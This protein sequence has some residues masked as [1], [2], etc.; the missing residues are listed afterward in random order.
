MTIFLKQPAKVVL[1]RSVIVDIAPPVEFVGWKLA[2]G[3]RSLWSDGGSNALETAFVNCDIKLVEHIASRE[4]IP[5]QFRQASV[6]IEVA[7]LRWRHFIVYWPATVAS[8]IP[9]GNARNFVEM[10]I[11]D[12]LTAWYASRARQNFEC[13]RKFFLYDAREGMRNDLLTESEGES[14]SS[15]SYLDNENTRKNLNLC[16]SEQFVFVK[17]YIQ[18]SFVQSGNIKQIA[19]IHLDL[20][21]S[22]PTI[23]S[24]DFFWDYLLPEGVVLL[25]DFALPGYENTKMEVEKWCQA[26]DLDILQLPTGQALIIK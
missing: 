3:T 26:R 7:Q 10:G 18:E 16:G 6:S 11:C 12:G 1:G 23:A 14:A 20:N 19:W 2:T 22:M 15:Y 24:L 13:G 25:N 21:S 9:D 17:G 8:K 4:V 5:T